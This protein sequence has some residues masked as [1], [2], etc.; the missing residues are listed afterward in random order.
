LV[1]V[2]VRVKGKMMIWADRLGLELGLDVRVGVRIRVRIRV[3]D[4]VRGLG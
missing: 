4:R 2:R 1:R 3:R